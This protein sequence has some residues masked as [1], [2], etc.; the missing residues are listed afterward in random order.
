[1]VSHIISAFYLPLGNVEQE[2]GEVV[3]LSVTR[4]VA[5]IDKLE[6]KLNEKMVEEMVKSESVHI[7][8]S[9]E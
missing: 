2:S 8:K 7:A 1:M 3:I 5:G 4:G 6:R 9:Q